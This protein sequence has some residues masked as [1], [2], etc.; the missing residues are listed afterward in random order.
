VK[1]S[2]CRTVVAGL[3][4]LGFTLP[5]A[6]AQQV[7]Q[8]PARTAAPS[9]T[10]VAVLDI[11]EVFEKNLRF[12]AAMDDIRED[13]KNYEATVVEKRKQAT[14]LNENWA[15]TNRVRRSTSRWRLNLLR[16]LPTCR[17]R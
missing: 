8:Q 9:G 15:S 16:W 3:L 14:T 10:N 7:G 6:V 2:V 17:W 1:I 12:K 11:N 5:A 13:I 4:C